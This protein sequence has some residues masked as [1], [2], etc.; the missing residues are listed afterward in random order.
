[1]NPKTGVKEVTFSED[2]HPHSQSMG[3]SYIIIATSS[4]LLGLIYIVSVLL[5]L[6]GKKKKSKYIGNNN[7]SLAVAEEGIVKNNPLLKHCHDNIAYLSDPPSGSDS[8]EEN[9]IGSA[10]DDIRTHKVS[11]S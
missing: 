2:T 3:S 8:E 6:Q 10:S 11:I 4:V 7:S 1:M 5:Y 9:E